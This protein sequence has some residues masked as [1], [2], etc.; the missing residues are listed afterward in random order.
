MLEEI[1]PEKYRYNLREILCLVTQKYAFDN[2]YQLALD[3]EGNIDT[4]AL[5]QLFLKDTK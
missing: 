4:S 3:T 2:Y 5:V 1:T